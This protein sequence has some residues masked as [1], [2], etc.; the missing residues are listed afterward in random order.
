MTTRYHTL[1]LQDG[2]D[3]YL[4]IGAREERM[5]VYLIDEDRLIRTRL[6]FPDCTRFMPE[7]DVGEEGLMRRVHIEQRYGPIPTSIKAKPAT[8]PERGG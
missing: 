2:E 5:R 4:A 3:R 6:L 8:G 1:Q 7:L